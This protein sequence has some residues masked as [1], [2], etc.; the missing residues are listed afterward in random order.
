VNITS[1][2]D[3][4]VKSS[5]WD[6]EGKKRITAVDDMPHDWNFRISRNLKAGQ[7]RLNVSTT[8]AG[9]G[10][11][12]IRMQ[13]RKELAMERQAIP[14]SIKKTISTEVLKI[15]FS[16]DNS[17]NLLHIKVKSRGSLKLALMRNDR[18]L[19]EGTDQLYIPLPGLRQYT[20]LAWAEEEASGETQIN[21]APVKLRDVRVNRHHQTIPTST[22]VQLRNET[23][24]SFYLKSQSGEKDSFYYS[25]LPERPCLLV[26]EAVEG[27][28]NDCGWLVGSGKQVR[29]ETVEVKSGRSTDVVL[30][31]IPLAFK[32]NQQQPAPLLLEVKSVSALMGAAVFPIELQPDNI[33]LRSGMLAAPSRTL[34]GIPGS[35]HYRVHTWRT[36]LTPPVTSEK[37][38]FHTGERTRFTLTAYPKQKEVDF[39]SSAAIEAE[40]QAGHSVW[41]R[42]KEEP[43]L[44][45]MTLAHGLAAFSWHQGRAVDIAAALDKNTRKKM[46]V[47]G[48]ILYVVN[49]RGY[50]ARFRAEKR[51]APPTGLTTL[52][53]IQGF[54]KILST[55]GTLQFHFSGIP[56]GKRLFVAGTRVSSQLWG[57]DGKIYRGAALKQPKNFD[58]EFYETNGGFLEI[59][60]WPG[61]V[62]IWLASTADNGRSFIGNRGT[63][64][65][66]LFKDGMG[67]LTPHLQEW[68]FF[69]ES[70]GYISVETPV[71]TAMA[72]VSDQE[73]LYISAEA[74]R[75]GHQLNHYLP[76]GTYR[77]LTRPLPGAGSGTLTLKTITPILLEEEKEIAV[78]LIRPG[79]IQVFRFHVQEQ[80]YVGVG[81]KTEND[82]LDAQLFDEKSHLAATGPLVLKKLPP[83]TYLLVVKT[84]DVP[85]QY[86]PVI[87]G[88][89]G[90]REGVPDDVIRKYKKE[91]DR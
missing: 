7:Y 12:E 53:P 27:T 64:E 13:T 25:P 33:F 65:K 22:A 86:R 30:N 21:A 50:P 43:Q 41:L 58:M 34:V 46:K 89:K 81:L 83:G 8:D 55:A 39:R 26:K 14:F 5:L 32:I 60:H 78:Q 3:V 24:L 19:A 9:S 29:L 10:A 62:K 63:A 76:P 52:D 36:A 40:V 72:L 20:L 31:D 15:P 23:G 17:E 91:A 57:T 74:F 11:V 67:A 16:T 35:G 2:G 90:S 18:L 75:T 6:K 79:E 73:I 69:M 37:N 68:E 49:T 59:R 51:G 28:S 54:E 47:H 80:G 70:A 42:I 61:L 85:V 1:F 45:E 44:L 56:E 48:E 88:T 84:R 87:L 4:D 77:L 38:R 71:P 82:S 66:A